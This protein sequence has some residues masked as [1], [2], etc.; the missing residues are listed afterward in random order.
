MHA[1][2]RAAPTPPFMVALMG[3][4]GVCVAVGV[5]ALRHLGER[6]AGLTIAGSVCYLAAIV[7]TAAYHV[8]RNEALDTVDP[9]ATDAIARW[10]HYATTWTAWNH[11]RTLTSVAACVLFTL[12]VSQG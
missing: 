2:N 4:A 1:I 6:A 12:A 7:L 9:R 8:P 5:V 11:A 3:T 10:H